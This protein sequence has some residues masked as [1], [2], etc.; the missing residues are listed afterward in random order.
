MSKFYRI[1]KGG[2]LIETSIKTF[3]DVGIFIV[4]GFRIYKYDIVFF[5]LDCF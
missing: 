3:I 1:K 2:D 4:K 5:V